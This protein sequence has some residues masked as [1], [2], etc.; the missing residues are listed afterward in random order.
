MYQRWVYLFDIL[1]FSGYSLVFPL[2]SGKNSM[3]MWSGR[4][5]NNQ[6]ALFA[7]V[8][9]VKALILTEDRW[10]FWAAEK[11]NYSDN[12]SACACVLA[13]INQNNQSYQSRSSCQT[14][15]SL[16]TVGGS[17]KRHRIWG[18]KPFLAEKWNPTIIWIFSIASILQVPPLST[19]LPD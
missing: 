13:V 12:Y 4:R 14:Y 5:N 11:A 3:L 6:G 16:P 17:I 10:R 2:Q 9:W 15:Q 7:N 8:P 1:H 19:T 18:A